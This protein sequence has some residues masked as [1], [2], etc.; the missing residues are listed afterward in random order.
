MGRQ[1][2]IALMPED[3]EQF[4]AFL[5]ASGDVALYRAWSPTPG[6]V[7]S[8]EL[9]EAASRFWIHNLAF[10]WEP[11]FEEIEYQD[12]STGGPAS[13]FRLSTHHAP[14]IEYSRHPMG[15]TNP[16]VGGRL[17]WEKRFMSQPH[18]IQYDIAAFDA[19]FSFVAKWV[20]KHGKKVLHG[21][22]EP[23]ALPA[24]RFKLVGGLEYISP[25]GTT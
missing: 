16:Q 24:A 12:K 23:W 17:Y 1:I 20:R 6:P 25:T 13:Y 7:S 18:E 21:E 4:L 14:L 19:W 10:G 2:S 22:T 8:F 3:E 9:A 5:K 11:V 15:A